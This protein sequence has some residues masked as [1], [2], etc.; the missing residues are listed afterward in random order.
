MVACLRGTS[1]K[2]VLLLNKELIR[3]DPIEGVTH[4]NDNPIEGIIH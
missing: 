2:R 3:E 4:C 1:L